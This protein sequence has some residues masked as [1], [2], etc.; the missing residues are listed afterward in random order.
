M[1]VM[2]Y[3]IDMALYNGTS[4]STQRKKLKL[5]NDLNAREV[6]Q[7]VLDHIEELRLVYQA[8]H[9]LL[10]VAEVLEVDMFLDMHRYV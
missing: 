3:I 7:L 2:Y 8:V 5:Y 1:I 4:L 6:E 10:V 9:Q